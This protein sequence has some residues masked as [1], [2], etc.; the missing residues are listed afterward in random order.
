MALR[1]RAVQVAVQRDDHRALRLYPKIPQSYNSD[2]D[3]PILAWLSHQVG[4][5]AQARF[6]L[7]ESRALLNQRKGESVH[8][9]GTLL[10]RALFPDEAR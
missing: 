8:L 7:G 5:S 9:Y 4:D 3:P 10:L 1:A 6:Y 2:Y